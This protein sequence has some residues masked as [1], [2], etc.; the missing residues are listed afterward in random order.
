MAGSQLHR[1]GPWLSSVPAPPGVDSPVSQTVLACPSAAASQTNIPHEAPFYLPLTSLPVKVPSGRSPVTCLLIQSLA[2]LNIKSSCINKISVC[3]FV[4]VCV[5]HI[6]LLRISFHAFALQSVFVCLY[7][8]ACINL[9]VYPSLFPETLL[10]P[11][12]LL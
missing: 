5:L 10:R 1:T 8:A 6:L 3:A 2:A 11:P 12:E 9:Q 7:V 4:C